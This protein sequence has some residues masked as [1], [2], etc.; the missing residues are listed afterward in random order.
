MCIL[1]AV[2]VDKVVIQELTD[3]VWIGGHPYN[4]NKL[5]SVTRILTALGNGIAE[6]EDF[7]SKL[8]L[9]NPS[10]DSQRFFPFIRHFLVGDRVVKFSYEAYLI[11]SSPESQSKAI[12]LAKTEPEEGQGSSREVV[13]KFVQRYNPKAHRLLATARCAPDLL[14]YSKDD[15]DFP[16]LGGLI[17]VVMGYID[18]KTAH[19]R[20]GNKPLPRPIFDRIQEA[21]KILHDEGIVFADLRLPNIMITRNEQAMLVDFDWCGVHGVDTYPVTLNDNIE[22]SNS[23]SWHPDV[24][25]GGTMVKEHDLFRLRCMGPQPL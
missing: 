25:R 11:G 16:D 23:I 17:M 9:H 15:H 13:I 8:S 12:F 6:L 21:V 4:D 22:S 7:Y 18:G 24:K 5:K 20:Y 3:F 19:D 14:Y 1:G 2:F 10:P